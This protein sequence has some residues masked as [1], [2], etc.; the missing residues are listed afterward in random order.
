[1]AAAGEDLE[2]AATDTQQLT[3]NQPAK[4]ARQAGDH[5]QVAMAA[6][7]QPFGGA[8]VETVRTIEAAVGLGVERA[9]IEMDVEADEVFG[10]AHQQRQAEAFAQPAGEAHM[11]GMVVRDQDTAERSPR[12]R[13]G[14]QRLPG[15][16]RRRVVEA[17]IEHRPAGVVLDQ[18][19]VD[20]IETERQREPDP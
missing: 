9:G 13:P 10:L 8:V 18:V 20:V 12:K 17:G 4:R 3:G 19:D 14:E 1:V 11:V 16:A 2:G 6:G 5:A 7:E 15:G